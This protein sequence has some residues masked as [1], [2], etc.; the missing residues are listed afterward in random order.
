MRDALLIID[1]QNAGNQS[2]NFY[3]AHIRTIV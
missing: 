3:C 2:V 1:V